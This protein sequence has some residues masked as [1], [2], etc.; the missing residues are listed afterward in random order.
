MLGGIGEGMRGGRG[1]GVLG[2]E[3]IE[4]DFWEGYFWEWE[5]GK[6]GKRMDWLGDLR[7]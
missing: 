4:R 5:M 6:G 3:C 2:G 1:G 7:G